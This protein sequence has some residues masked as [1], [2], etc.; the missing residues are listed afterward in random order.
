MTDV[1]WLRGFSLIATACGGNEP[2]T[3]QTKTKTTH[4]PFAIPSLLLGK[5]DNL[6]D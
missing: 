6:I 1:M 2:H 3:L 4:T 5:S